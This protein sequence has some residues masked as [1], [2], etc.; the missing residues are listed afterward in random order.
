MGNQ[1]L[2]VELRRRLDEHLD[3][4]SRVADEADGRSA[5]VLMRQAV[6]GLV[7]ALRVLTDEHR[8]DEDGNCRKCRGG[9][10]WRR[11]PAPCRILLNVH[12]AAGSA[13]ATTRAHTCWVPRRHRLAESHLD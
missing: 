13:T 3:L 6:P 1:V 4:L 11:V 12:L 5:L 2:F 7:A 10:F 8:P 9:P